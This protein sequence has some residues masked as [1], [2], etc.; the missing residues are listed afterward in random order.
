[1]NTGR[2]YLDNAATSFPKPP[3]VYE[4][5]LA[6]GRDIGA[7]PGRAS[8]A[9]SREGGRIIRRCR[10]QL[11]RWIGGE[12]PDHVVFTLNTTDALNLAIR[13]AVRH[14]R[15]TSPG[16]PIHLITTQFDHNSVLRPLNALAEEGVEWTCIPASTGSGLL[17][18]DQIGSAI[19]P[20]TLMVAINHVSNVTGTIQPAGQVGRLCRDRG[21]LFLLDAAQS[22]G[23]I[24]VDAIQ[25]GADLLAM[26]GHKGLLGPLGTGALYIRPG[27]ER[28][29]DAVRQGGTGTASERDTHPEFL[30]D[31]YEPGSHNAVGIAGL[32]VAVEWLLARGA[33]SIREHELALVVAVLEG[34][35][36]GGAR[37]SDDPD[38]GGPGPFE[39]LLL[40]GCSEPDRRT[41]IFSLIHRHCPP[42]RLA[43]LLEEK[44]DILARPGIHCAPRAHA[45]LGTAPGGP[46]C[47][48]AG[49]GAM[50][51]SFGPFVGVPD[52]R[53]TIEAL[54]QVCE[55]VR[56][57]DAT[58]HRSG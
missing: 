6:Y 17:D 46:L 20:E 38:S 8:Y 21:V 26:P 57:A 49:A 41:A 3:G 25:C 27:V 42:Q 10:E 1:M 24:P 56:P 39:D 37:A 7:T 51:L 14:R 32:L 4:A 31:K 45:A 5:M 53:R 29:I 40:L 47:H 55:M 50:R 9:E 13:G 12:S 54:A 48:T 52:A 22:L 30:P 36:S 2:L 28:V 33:P 16:R 35:R 15:R 18:P 43:Q 44:F 19:R 23:H 34:L 11:C 58:A